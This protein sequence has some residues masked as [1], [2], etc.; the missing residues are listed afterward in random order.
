M[1]EANP[2]RIHHIANPPQPLEPEHRDQVFYPE[3]QESKWK[4]PS[5][6]HGGFPATKQDCTIKRHINKEFSLLFEEARLCDVPSAA[7]YNLWR[8]FNYC[9]IPCNVV[10]TKSGKAV[11]GLIRGTNG[12]K[13][14]RLQL[15]YSQNRPIFE[16]QR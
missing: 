15:V 2:S 11:S 12:W 1:Q 16:K 8:V 4:N 6:P 13:R 3:L 14:M 5:D 10:R 7:A 9:N